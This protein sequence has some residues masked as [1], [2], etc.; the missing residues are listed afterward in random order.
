M[1][2]LF[3]RFVIVFFSKLVEVYVDI[4]KNFSL[5]F[6]RGPNCGSCYYATKDYRKTRQLQNVGIFD[7]VGSVPELL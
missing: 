4:S 7:R 1:N 3:P 5:D 2:S 6:S